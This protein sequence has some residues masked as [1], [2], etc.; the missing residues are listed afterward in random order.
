MECK[1]PVDIGLTS[2]A[3]P[4][5][6]P[7][8]GWDDSEGIEENT[9]PADT[10]ETQPAPVQKLTEDE[11]RQMLVA[12]VKKTNL[13]LAAALQKALRWEWTKDQLLLIFESTYEA[14]L[15][16]NAAD[17]LR[18]AAADAGIP[19]LSIKTRTEIRATQSQSE[20]VSDRTKLVQQVFRGQIVKG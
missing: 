17:V 1:V 5:P 8:A 9:P 14:A 4:S 2:P 20:S 13:S 11:S 10:V 15:V 12:E 16:A 19:P 7:E 18:K 6:G 3:A